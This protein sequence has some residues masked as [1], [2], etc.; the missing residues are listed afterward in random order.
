M[1]RERK[2]KKEK[3]ARKKKKVKEREKKK[4][5]EIEREIK[6]KIKKDTCSRTFPPIKFA[7]PILFLSAYFAQLAVSQPEQKLVSKNRLG[8]AL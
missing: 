1:D 5:K 6:K 2:R 3:K 7:C 4:K 8:W